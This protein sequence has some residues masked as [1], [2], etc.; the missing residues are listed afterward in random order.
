MA[1]N[2]AKYRSK[3]LGG[4]A[5]KKIIISSL[6]ALGALIIAA[7]V[8]LLVL[9]LTRK[10]LSPGIAYKY[11]DEYGG[12]EVYA[13]DKTITEA[14]IPEEIDGTPV[15]ALKQNAFYGCSALASISLPDTLVHI[16]KG[17]LTGISNDAYTEH[18]NVAK[19]LGN[20]DNPYLVL[21]TVRDL[22]D[23]QYFYTEQSTR[24]VYDGAFANLSHIVTVSLTNV[25]E[26]GHAAFFF[27]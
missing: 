17:A 18:N 26:I 5:K 24:F 19:Y 23:V 13:T 12:F 4:N 25:L 9:F 10:E 16:G 20:E 8:I 3:D 2:T 22:E 7:A 11:N 15:V 1:K 6:I 21:I 14:F 27:C